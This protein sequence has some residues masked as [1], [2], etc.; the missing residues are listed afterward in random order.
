MHYL[1]TECA[2]RGKQVISGEFLEVMAHLYAK[3]GQTQGTLSSK[4]GC[5]QQA[6]SRA[7][8][9]LSIYKSGGVLEGW[10]FVETRPD[11][12]NRRELALWLTPE[13]RDF[14]QGFL[15]ALYR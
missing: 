1:R 3:D 10:R 5:S 4:I 12:E 6:I 7:G 14:M 2:K 11:L 8:K 9:V 15:D 13:G